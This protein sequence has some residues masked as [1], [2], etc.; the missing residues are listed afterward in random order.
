MSFLRG[1]DDWRPGRQDPIASAEHEHRPT[2]SGHLA[3]GSLAC[4]RCDAPVALAGS[5]SLT[6]TLT[7]P[8]CANQGPVRDFLSLAVPTRPA[9]VELRVTLRTMRVVRDSCDSRDSRDSDHSRGPARAD[10]VGKPEP[11]AAP[12]QA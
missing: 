11:R 3:S 8:F 2:R 12:G 10:P 9:R 4:A 5:L 6:D 7:C 1:V